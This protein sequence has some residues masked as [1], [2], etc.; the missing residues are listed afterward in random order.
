[1][2]HHCTNDGTWLE[3]PHVAVSSCAPE[4][5]GTL[6][7]NAVVVWCNE[8]ARGNVHSHQ[9]MLFI[10]AGKCGAAFRPLMNAMG[11]AGDTFGNPAHC[12]GPLGN[13]S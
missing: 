2:C 6:L 3:W 11:V 5:S 13:L 1:M 10:L 7:D 4:G 9:P 12:T 8:L